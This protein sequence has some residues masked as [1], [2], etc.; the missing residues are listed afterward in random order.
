[1]SDTVRIPARHMVTANMPAPSPDPRQDNLCSDDMRVDVDTWIED[2]F[3]AGYSSGYADGTST[4][5]RV[6]QAW[7]TYKVRLR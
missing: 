5:W 6:N 2:A 1:M 3:R 4:E 7:S